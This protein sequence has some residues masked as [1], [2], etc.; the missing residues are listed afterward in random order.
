M[1][2]LMNTQC[3]QLCRHGLSRSLQFCMVVSEGHAFQL[4]SF[5]SDGK[6]WDEVLALMARLLVRDGHNS[7]LLTCS[8]N[9]GG[10]G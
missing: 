4:H 2:T 3:L 6:A 9:F 5:S 1:Y 8:E 7:F 10:N